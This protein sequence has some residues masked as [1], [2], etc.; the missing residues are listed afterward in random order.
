MKIEKAIEML[1]MIEDCSD[2]A[3][4]IFDMA[5]EHEL[6]QEEYLSMFI[7]NLELTEQYVSVI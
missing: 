4:L 3:D 6:K 5:A 1:S 7:S 2:Y